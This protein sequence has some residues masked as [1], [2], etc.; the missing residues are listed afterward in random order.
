MSRAEVISSGLDLVGDI[1][2]TRNNLFLPPHDT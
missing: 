2:T 1:A